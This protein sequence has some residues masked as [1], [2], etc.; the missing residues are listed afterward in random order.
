MG[1]SVILDLIGSTLIGSMLLLLLINMNANGTEKL[2]TFS[3]DYRIQLNLVGFVDLLES[4]FKRMGYCEDERLVA[5]SSSIAILNATTNSITFRTDLPANSL[6]IRGDGVFDN[7]TYST[8][9]TT[10]ADVASTPNPRDVPFIRSV[11]GTPTSQS[12]GLTTLSFTYYDVNGNNLSS[13]VTNLNNINRIQID[14]VVEDPYGYDVGSNQSFSKTFWQ[15]MRL[16]A[17]NIS[18]R[19]VMTIP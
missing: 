12:F 18:R 13:P 8:G 10:D 19:G 1:A 9:S 7:V 16:S 17:K 3:G 6:S 15:Q 2:Y 11:N 4:D 5:G 14:V